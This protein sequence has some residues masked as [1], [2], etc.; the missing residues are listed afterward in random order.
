MLPNLR[1][2]ILSTLL[3]HVYFYETHDM[4]DSNKQGYY[5]FESDR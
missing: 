3:I 1:M 2:N 5:S 4:G